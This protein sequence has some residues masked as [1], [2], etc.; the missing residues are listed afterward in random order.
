MCGLH[1]TFLLGHLVQS[2]RKLSLVSL[3]SG[4]LL[5]GLLSILLQVLFV[6]SLAFFQKFIDSLIKLLL[7]LVLALVVLFLILEVAA[8]KC[9]L[10][11]LVSLHI[12]GVV[13]MQVVD[14]ALKTVVFTS[15]NLE[16][17]LLLLAVLSH[18]LL[19]V[20]QLV[21]EVVST[22]L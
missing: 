14:L 8:V 16:K 15:D 1:L 13:L 20:L 18:F 11:L 7:L 5:L 22:V 21:V 2:V 10:V 9:S 6:S 12:V 19:L 17:L 4:T 3:I